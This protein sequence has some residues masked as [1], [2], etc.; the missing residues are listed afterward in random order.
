MKPVTAYLVFYN[1]A[2]ALGWLYVL[3]GTISS[4]YS[5][6]ADIYS[7]EL[8][9]NDAPDV[10]GKIG[11]V[12]QVVQTTACLELLHSILGWV[13]SPIFTVFIQVGSRILV[14]WFHTSAW[15]ECQTLSTLPMMLVAWAVTEVV[16][17]SFYTCGC[18]MPSEKIPFPLSDLVD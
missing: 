8:V 12:L 5:L 14:L 4:K 15:A 2:S 16:R 17:Y 6:K 10:W 3:V 1:I 7:I 13:R 11:P 18:L 9:A